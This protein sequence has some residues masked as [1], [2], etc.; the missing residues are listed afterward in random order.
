MKYLGLGL[1]VLSTL[2]YI[3]VFVI[4]FTSL[5]LK[6]KAV[7]V[8][9]LVVAGEVTFWV[10]AVLVGKELVMKY[11]SRLNPRNWFRKKEPYCN[12]DI[13]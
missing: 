9:A 3:C 2:L 8:P 13:E 7:M 6:V 1:I 5:S 4:P 12:R 10:G 11:R